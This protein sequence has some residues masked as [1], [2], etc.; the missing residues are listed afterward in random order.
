MMQI[1]KRAVAVMG[2]VATAARTARATAVAGVVTATAVD[3]ITAIVIV[4]GVGVIVVE[5]GVTA[6][7]LIVRGMGV[8][9]GKGR[10]ERGEN[11]IKEER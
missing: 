4:V 5:V 7:V 9:R 11:M 1:A 10:M 6:M 2:P 3:A 8:Q